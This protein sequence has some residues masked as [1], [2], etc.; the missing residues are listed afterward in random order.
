MKTLSEL[1]ARNRTLLI[2]CLIGLSGV[3]LDLIVYFLLIGLS[4]ANYQVANAIGYLSGTLLSFVL[5]SRY[6]F[7]VRD[8]MI[9]R[10]LLFCA[11]AM[12]GFIASAFAI[13]ILVEVMG[14]NRY[15]SK[16]ATLVAV[17]MIQYNLNRRLSFRQYS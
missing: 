9:A 5:N 13:H 1:F 7:R 14:I 16:V 10:L 2:Y 6:N 3:L 8:R 17:V 4:I 15:L 11:V 12:S